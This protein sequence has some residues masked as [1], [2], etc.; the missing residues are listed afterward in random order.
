MKVDANP[1]SQMMCA[2]GKGDCGDN[3]YRTENPSNDVDP[4]ASPALVAF[5]QYKSFDGR[6]VNS[7]RFSANK[8]GG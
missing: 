8:S 4:Q 7:F 5:R 3:C 1:E 2:L 6:F